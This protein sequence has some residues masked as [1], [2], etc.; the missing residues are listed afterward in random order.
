MDEYLKETHMLNYSHPAIQKLIH[1]KHWN[2]INKF[3]RIQSIYNYV[4]D[5]ILPFLT[6]GYIKKGEKC[7][8][9]GVF[10]PF[11]IVVWEASYEIFFIFLLSSLG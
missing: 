8:F 1:D 4:R 3:E 9:K 11:K 7:L 6:V 10:L 5:D 2:E